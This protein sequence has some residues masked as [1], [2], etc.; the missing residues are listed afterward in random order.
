MT[1]YVG[2]DVHSK[3]SVFV[4]QD[5]DGKIVGRGE[6]PTSAEGM[7]RLRDENGLPAGTKVALE[8]GTVAFFAARKLSE[9]GLT[10]IVVDAHEV[11]I[12]AHRPTQKSDRRD[13]LEL[14]EGI[15][16]NS[17]RSIVHVP[18]VSVARLRE[19]LSRRRHFVRAQTSEV[20][21]VKRLLR[22]EGLGQLA[23]SLRTAAGWG[24][25]AKALREHDPMLTT[26]VEH[27]RLVW[28]SA[29]EQIDKLEELLETQ[30]APFEQDVKRLQTVPG[31]GRI[32]ALTAVAIFSDIGR[33]PSSKEAAS[34]VGLV[35]STHQSGDRHAH[36]KITKRGSTELRAMLCEAA[37]HAARRHN[38]LNPYFRKLCAK[39]G[40]KMAVVAVA[41]RLCRILYSML[42]NRTDF[43]EGK[44]AVERGPFE[45]KTQDLYRL[46]VVP[47]TMSNA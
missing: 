7:R 23:R 8:T 17:Y 45:R 14:C 27:H 39:H 34:Y 25:L 20:N 10:P 31:V 13:A 40:Y 29:G 33:F 12:K 36:G 26:Y 4:I 2:L 37:H 18:P 38:P 46:R 35:P 6:I 24:K 9:V 5:E 28:Q 22:S 3:M 16:R 15:R 44:L 32:V 11:R 42:K 30:R 1:K 47:I 21:A 19:S 43:D 41:H